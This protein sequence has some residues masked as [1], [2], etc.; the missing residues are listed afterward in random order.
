M[1]SNNREQQF[2]NVVSV[3]DTRLV[4]TYTQSWD[5]ES[6]SRLHNQRRLFK[7]LKQISNVHSIQLDYMH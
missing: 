4:A 1:K 7:N 2:N 5:M 6:T 3:K